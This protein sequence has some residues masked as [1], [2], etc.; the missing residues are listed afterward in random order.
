MA[1]IKSDYLVASIEANK[2]GKGALDNREISIKDCICVEGVE[3]RAGSLALE[4]YKPLFDATVVRKLKEAGGLIVGKTTQDEFGFGSFNV[5][6]G[7]GFDVP[8]NPLDSSRVCGGSSGGAAAIVAQ[9]KI[10]GIKHIAIAESTGGSIVNPAA[11]CGVIGLCP[12]YGL[13][14]RYGLI[15]YANSLDKIGVIAENVEDAAVTLSVISGFDE[16]D[17]TSV[18]RKKENYENYLE[19]AGKEKLKIAVIRDQANLCDK[20]VQKALNELVSKLKKKHSVDEVELP[21]NNEHALGVYYIIAMAEASTNLAKYSGMRYG[22]SEA[23]KDGENYDEYFS[24]VRSKIFGKEAKR[25]III[26]TFTRMAGYRD[27]YYAKALKVRTKIIREWKKH[28]EKYDLLLCPTMPDVA[29]RFD[30][31][32]K[33]TP[34]QNYAMDILT[35]GPNLAGLPHIS[36]PFDSKTV[37]EE[38]K[39]RMPI[40]MMF[41][42]DHF[43]EKYLIQIGKEVLG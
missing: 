14:S 16:Q 12:T 35:V 5:N 8:K 28:F 19:K 23:L 27:A 1:K 15:D 43:N 3:S 17:N 11:Y 22:Y 20:D 6:V 13:I 39:I 40:G 21:L 37:D 30:E 33:L 41:V 25:R 2:Y 36:V 9:R 38:N 32:N 24:R 42:A 31:I 29:P 18:D 34:A 4:G 10:E 7:I 26:G